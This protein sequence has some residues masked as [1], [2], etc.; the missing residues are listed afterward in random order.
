MAAHQAFAHALVRAQALPRGERAC[1]TAAPAAKKYSQ[2]PAL[3]ASGDAVDRGAARARRA[4][5]RRIVLDVVDD[6]RAGVQALDHQRQLRWQVPGIRRRGDSRARRS[7]ARK[8]LPGRAQELAQ[9]PSSAWSQSGVRDLGRCRGVGIVP[10]DE[11][12]GDQLQERRLGG[13]RLRGFHVVLASCL[14]VESE[15]PRG[16]R[17]TRMR[18]RS[19]GV[20]VSE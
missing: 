9:R 11:R 14:A 10:V 15:K 20:S 4:A 7:R 2:L 17:P 6:Q 3:S 13:S 18:A 16:G 19:S 8:P 12:A 5:R 1:A